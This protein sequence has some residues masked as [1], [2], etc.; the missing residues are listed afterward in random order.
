MCVPACALIDSVENV[1]SSPRAISFTRFNSK[2]GSPGHGTRPF[3]NR[4]EIS[5]QRD[6]GAEIVEQ[7][8]EKDELAAK[9]FWK[10]TFTCT[11]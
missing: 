5:I 8:V 3:R 7:A 9:L 10:W 1:H 4:T 2:G 11:R 6:I